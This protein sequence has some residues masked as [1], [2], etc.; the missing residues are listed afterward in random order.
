MY[1]KDVKTGMLVFSPELNIGTVLG[2]IIITDIAQSDINIAVCNHEYSSKKNSPSIRH[3][4]NIGID[5]CD[6]IYIYWDD[7]RGLV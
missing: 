2:R 5:T 3:C 6:S 1:D 4:M 7:R